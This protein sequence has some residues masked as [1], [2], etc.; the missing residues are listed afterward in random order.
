MNINI[1]ARQGGFTLVEIAIVL[2]IIGLLLVG[3]LQGQEMIENGKVK[4]LV[5]DM[6][7][8]SAAY[9]AYQDRYQAIP[10][11][12]LI[13]STRFTGADNGGGN[14]LIT[15]LFDAIAAPA[16]AT[17]SN[18]FW[19]HTR[20]AGLLSG[21]ATAAAALP[22]A[23]NFG[24]VIGV[25]SH[26][27]A[28]GGT[29]YGMTGNVV[30]ASQVPWRTALSIDL[31]LDDGVSGTGKVRSG[32]TN[33]TATA[34]AAAAVYGPAVAASAVLEAGLHTICMKL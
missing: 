6:K 15:G 17:E 22:Q 28:A 27:T 12:D 29:T 34:T 23:N 20:M 33:V 16:A 24:G 3:V 32:A 4:K 19:Q 26:V 31:Q 30:C 11:D 25:Q 7:G 2:V 14:G 10:G 18:N 9:Y 1:K 13:A 8:V 5:A 21:V